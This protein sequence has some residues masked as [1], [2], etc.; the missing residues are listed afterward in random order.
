MI[1]QRIAPSLCKRRSGFGPV[2]LLFWRVPPCALRSSPSPCPSLLRHSFLCRH[3]LSQT[4]GVPSPGCKSGC[5]QP[6]IAT[7][8]HG[9]D[10][11]SVRPQ[12]KRP[13]QP[14]SGCRGRR[15]IVPP[16]FEPGQRESKSLVLP[17]HHGTN[18]ALA[19]RG[20]LAARPGKCKSKNPSTAPNV[21]TLGLR[22]PWRQATMLPQHGLLLSHRKAPGSP[23]R[24]GSAHR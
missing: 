14:S 21:R 6:T 20:I 8:D 4:R 1:R 24:A 13:R 23:A 5:G 9:A 10:S 3:P 2:P 15:R 7:T 12:K 18:A 16:G 11:D 22:R 17:L 19:R